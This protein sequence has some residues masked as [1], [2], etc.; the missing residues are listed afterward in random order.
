[1]D[2]AG[3]GSFVALIPSPLGIGTVTLEDGGRAQGFLCE[4]HA[5]EGAEDITADGGWRVYLARA[6]GI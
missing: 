5:L 6:Q 1:M 3:F 2:H 4:P